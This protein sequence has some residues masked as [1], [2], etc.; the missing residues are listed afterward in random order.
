MK[1]T[2]I[3]TGAQNCS[4]GSNYGP[5]TGSINA[6]MIKSLKCEY[7]ILG[8]SEKRA[9]GETDNIINRKIISALQNNLKVIFCIGE[10]FGQKKK[11]LTKKTLL[12]QISK[13]LKKIKNKKNIIIAYEPVW[14]IGSGMIPKNRRLRKYH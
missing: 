7:V 10:T 1:N 14:S 3:K 12:N 11:K 6:M 13:G 4:F 8:H 2:T 9:K 5:P